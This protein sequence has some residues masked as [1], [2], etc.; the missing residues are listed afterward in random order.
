MHFRRYI[1]IPILAAALLSCKQKGTNT[2]ADTTISKTDTLKSNTDTIR[3]AN[4]TAVDLPGDKPIPLKLLIVPGVSLGQTIINEASENIYKRFGRPD[5]GDA[6]MGKSISIWYANHDTTGYVT[7]MYFSTNMGNDD[8]KRVKQVRINSPAFKIN[9]K[10]HVG[11]PFTYAKALYKLTK[12]GTFEENGSPRS[13]YDDNKAGIAFETDDKNMITGIT[14]HQPGRDVTTTY[15][16][17]FPSLK[18]T[19]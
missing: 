6:A 7:Q 18:T 11:A 13:L 2:T 1:I 10:V 14:V 16:P 9:T 3:A 5:A 4:T 12:A 8:T 17:F 15:L 19:K